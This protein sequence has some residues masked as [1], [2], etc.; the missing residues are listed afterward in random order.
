MARSM[1]MLFLSRILVGLVKQ[2]MTLSN[3]ILSDLP[4]TRPERTEHLRYGTEAVSSIIA[5][6]PY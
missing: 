2:T 6:R 4:L 5:P 3:A 1:W